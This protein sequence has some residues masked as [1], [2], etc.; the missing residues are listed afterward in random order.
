MRIYRSVRL[1]SIDPM[2]AYHKQTSQHSEMTIEPQLG[3]KLSLV[4]LC[5]TAAF[6]RNPAPWQIQMP[7]FFCEHGLSI[8]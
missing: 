1:V 8:S 4:G 7:R 3:G 2:E 5:P 6:S